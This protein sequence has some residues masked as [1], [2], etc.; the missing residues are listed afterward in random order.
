MQ[1]TTGG[2]VNDIPWV[3]YNDVALGIKDRSIQFQEISIYPNPVTD[4]M[5]IENKVDMQMILISN[6]LGQEVMRMTL[7]KKR[8]YQLNTGELKRGLYILS[9]YGEHGY[10]GTAKFIKK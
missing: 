6:I 5:Y 3:W 10:V 9:V 8:S 2:F 7:D 1:D 4:M